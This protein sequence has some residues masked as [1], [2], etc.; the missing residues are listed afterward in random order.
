[1]IYGDQ[2]D[3]DK[4]STTV[5]A[6]WNILLLLAVPLAG[7]AIYAWIG[8]PQFGGQRESA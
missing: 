8:N 5:P 2:G 6:T 7:I 4:K 3:R 1:M